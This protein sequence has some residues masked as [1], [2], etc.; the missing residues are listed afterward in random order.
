MLSFIAFGV[1]VLLVGADQLIKYM[2]LE[3]LTKVT[4]LPLI[5]GVLHLTYVENRGAAFGFF[6]GQR[7]I[8]I[9]VT[10][11]V[12]L[13]MIVALFSGRFKQRMVL[14]GVALVIAGGAGN[15]IDRAMRGFVVDYVDFRLINFYVFNLA[16]ACVCIGVGLLIAYLLIVE[17]LREKRK[18]MLDAAKEGGTG[19]RN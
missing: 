1:A 11:L 10:G 6:Q 13:A 16:D 5:D 9:G 4:T 2:A 19:D 8:L 12:L 15:L 3:H 7:W 14:W 17:P 18:K